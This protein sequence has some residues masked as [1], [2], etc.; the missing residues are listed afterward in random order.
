[1]D[2]SR[3]LFLYHIPKTGGTSLRETL[4]DSLGFN[5]GFIHM[6]PYGDRVRKKT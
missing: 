1:M 2:D 3:I 6:G 5:E 4:S